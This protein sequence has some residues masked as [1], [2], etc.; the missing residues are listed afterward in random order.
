MQYNE[1][2]NKNK[3]EVIDTLRDLKKNCFM[4][5]FQA[6]GGMLQNTSLIRKCRRDIARVKTRLND[7]RVRG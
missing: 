5:S 3:Q 4:L 7:F 2:K 1:L 6:K